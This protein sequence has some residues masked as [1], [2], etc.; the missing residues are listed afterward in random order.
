MDFR[1]LSTG[2]LESYEEH[3][4][5]DLAA[6]GVAGELEID[7]VGRPQGGGPGLAC[8]ENA[9]RAFGCPREREVGSRSRASGGRDFRLGRALF[10]DLGSAARIPE[11]GAP[12]PVVARGVEGE[13][14][15]FGIDREHQRL[16]GK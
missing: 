9:R 8:Q 5:E 7:A 6:V 10:A 1:P 12:E 14:V 2:C 13:R 11:L 3:P 16:L 4:G 15:A